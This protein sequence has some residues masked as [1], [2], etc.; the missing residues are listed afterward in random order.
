MPGVVG[1]NEQVIV[2][3]A[4]SEPVLDQYPHGAPE[5]QVALSDDW[6]IAALRSVPDDEVVTD[7]RVIG[8]PTVTDDGETTSVVTG[9]DA[10][11]GGFTGD[12][13]AVCDRAVK[14]TLLLSHPALHAFVTTLIWYVPAGRLGIIK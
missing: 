7:E 9:R 6:S 13:G 10:T 5:V 12:V 8:E 11:V 1:M 2:C 14:V 4:F 3:R